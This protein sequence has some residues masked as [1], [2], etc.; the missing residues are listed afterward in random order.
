MRSS[1]SPSIKTSK[2]D[3][4]GTPLHPGRRSSLSG[5]TE[6]GMRTV[7][8]WQDD[9]RNGGSMNAER[10]IPSMTYDW[11]HMNILND[12]RSIADGPDGDPN[13]GELRYVSDGVILHALP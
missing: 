10:G 11:D 1:C 7:L 2:P 4:V 6:Q 8:N 3:A 9:R 13:D 12:Y 5:C